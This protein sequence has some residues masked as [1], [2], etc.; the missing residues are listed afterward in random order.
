VF[1]GRGLRNGAAATRFGALGSVV[2][3]RVLSDSKSP[4]RIFRRGLK[5]CDD[6]DLPVIC[7]MC[8]IILREDYKAPG[9]AEM[10]R[11]HAGPER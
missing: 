9:A 1:E 10:T 3:D 6:E 4:R 8:Q 11:N 5:S 7:P 2:P